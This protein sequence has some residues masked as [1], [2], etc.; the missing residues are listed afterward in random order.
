[1][2]E[3]E[4]ETKMSINKI[5][6]QIRKRHKNIKKLE[7]EI[8]NWTIALSEKR[9]K[10][11]LASRALS[12]PLWYRHKKFALVCINSKYL[13]H[14]LNFWFC[15][16]YKHDRWSLYH[17][18]E[19]GLYMLVDRSDA[20]KI[21]DMVDKTYTNVISIKSEKGNKKLDAFLK[22]HNIRWQYV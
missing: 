19:T 10:D 15:N 6:H 18:L 17:K 13:R 16:T 20:Q 22:L 12:E 5:Q 3:I 11:F 8:D 9:W 2:I 14:K 7:R 4:D 21:L 1:M